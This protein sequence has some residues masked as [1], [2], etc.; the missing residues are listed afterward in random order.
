MLTERDAGALRGL[1]G[2]VDLK[3]GLSACGED[4]ALYFEH[5]GS[6]ARRYRRH[7]QHLALGAALSEWAAV[8][9]SLSALAVSL[10]SI[11]AVKLADDA[12]CRCARLGQ[13]D[14]AYAREEA[15]AFC[16]ELMSL[17]AVIER[18]LRA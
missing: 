1:L 6:A 10:Q 14:T 16:D 11:G 5:L 8:R 13:G 17:C 3:E 2:C 7:A 9:L 4:A 12:A 18:C 15:D